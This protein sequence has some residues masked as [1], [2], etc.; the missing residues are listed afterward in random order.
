MKEH[1]IG[2][3]NDLNEAANLDVSHE[4]EKPILLNLF[5]YLTIT[6]MSFPQTIFPLKIVTD[7]SFLPV[8]K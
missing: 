8:I 3:L 7:I 5:K 2:S 1:A 6:T 4:G